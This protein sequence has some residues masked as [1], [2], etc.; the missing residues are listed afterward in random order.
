MRSPAAPTQ[1]ERKVKTTGLKT[2]HY[3]VSGGRKAGVEVGPEFGDGAGAV[4]LRT[5]HGAIEEFLPA[6][7]SLRDKRRDR[8]KAP[9]EDGALQRLEI[10]TEKRLDAA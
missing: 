8:G 4:F 3:K 6:R 2:G 10:G 5:C 1:A 9:F 7:G